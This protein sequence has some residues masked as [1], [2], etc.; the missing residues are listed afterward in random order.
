MG[1]FAER[2]REILLKYPEPWDFPPMVFLDI[3]NYCHI[4]CLFCW[5][6]SP[7]VG[8]KI[9]PVILEISD[10][11]RA[12]DK[13][14]GEQLEYIGV[15]GDGEPLLHPDLLE[16]VKFLRG[17]T[18]R[19]SLTTNAILF[20]E[21]P[22]LLNFLDS[23]SINCAGLSP[24]IYTYLHGVS[25]SE[26]KRFLG[27]LKLILTNKVRTRR[28]YIELVYIL[29]RENVHHIKDYLLTA[30]RLGID[31]IEFKIVDTVEQTRFLQEFDFQKSEKI[32]RTCLSVPI[33]LKHNL[34]EVYSGFRFDGSSVYDLDACYLPYFALF[35]NYDSTV[36]FCCHNESF[37]LGSVRNESLLS[38][39]R[40]PKAQSM[41]RMFVGGFDLSKSPWNEECRYCFWARENREIK[42]LLDIKDNECYPLY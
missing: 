7:L 24:E 22:E 39:W 32:I 33:K 42:D 27:S 35:I 23:V 15:S 25:I 29:T 20:S 40:S 36:R 31:E 38:I 30:D 2:H 16:I 26:W 17:K 12:F 14:E 41:R 18:K 9:D 5:E 37:V 1:N 11:K 8:K 13:I 28:P 21:R 19:L 4:R 34:E 10:I 6:H 3:I